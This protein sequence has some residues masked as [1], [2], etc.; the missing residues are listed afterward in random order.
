VISSFDVAAYIVKQRQK[1]S[2]KLTAMK[3]QNLLYYC[4]AWS[5]VREEA[6]LFTEEIQAWA[7]GPVIT[8]LYDW[9]RGMLYVEIGSKG[10]PD[11]LSPEQQ[12]TVDRI[13]DVYG[14]KTAQW[15]S[16]LTHMETPWKAARA[17]LQPGEWGSKTITHASLHEYYDSLDGDEKAHTIVWYTEGIPI[18]DYGIC[19]ICCHIFY[20][21]Y[22]QTNFYHG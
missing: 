11:A 8:E 3:L 19:C 13:L 10:D 7:M 21:I 18:L 20:N 2:S 14:H 9:H 1:G 5:L 4:Q 15:L 22:L 16:N 6:P 17:G 12:D